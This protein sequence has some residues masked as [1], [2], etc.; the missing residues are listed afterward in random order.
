LLVRVCDDVRWGCLLEVWLPQERFQGITKLA[1]RTQRRREVHFGSYPLRDP[2]FSKSSSRTW[3]EMQRCVKYISCGYK[4]YLG[5]RGPHRCWNTSNTSL[6]TFLD[7][8]LE[9]H[10]CWNIMIV[11]DHICNH[12]DTMHMCIPA[13]F[14][15]I[16]PG[17]KKITCCFYSFE[18][19]N[20]AEVWLDWLM[21][22]S[23]IWLIDV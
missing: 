14:A 11:F 10:C 16:L 2:V 7:H 13:T 4:N 21:R 20:R 9:F 1:I 18:A 22:E 3:S 6:P 5:Q 15:H 8:Y 12:C 17:W 19:T 23:L